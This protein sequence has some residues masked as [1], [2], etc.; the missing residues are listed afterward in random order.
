MQLDLEF[1]QAGMW[2]GAFIFS[3]TYF[4][5][6]PLS[7]PASKQSGKREVV[8][9]AALSSIYKGD[10]NYHNCIERSVYSCTQSEND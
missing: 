2:R 9:S 10:R 7:L 3:V 4:S 8:V 6:H 1:P 5:N